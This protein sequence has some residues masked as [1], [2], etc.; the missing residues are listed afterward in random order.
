MGG[1][2]GAGREGVQESD[3]MVSAHVACAEGLA[4]A[5][6]GEG[7][8]LRL[9]R[10]M[11]RRRQGLFVVRAKRLIV[12]SW[13]AAFWNRETGKRVWILASRPALR[14]EHENSPFHL[15]PLPRF[16]MDGLYIVLSAG[17][18]DGHMDLLV[19]PVAQLIEKTR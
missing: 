18:A 1:V 13:R 16:V 19:T 10:D 6:P 4:T 11:G 17:N 7:A 14:T 5:D 8:E 2:L 3:W 12:R 15:C 9:A